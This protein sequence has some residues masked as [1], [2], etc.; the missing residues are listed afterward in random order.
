MG[1]NHIFSQGLCM[2][3]A[4]NSMIKLFR[5]FTGFLFTYCFTILPLLEMSKLKNYQQNHDRKLR[6]RYGRGVAHPPPPPPAITLKK[7]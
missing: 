7:M 5:T 4:K 3:L 6:E 1:C 2:W